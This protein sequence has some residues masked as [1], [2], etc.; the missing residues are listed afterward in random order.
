[1]RIIS[2]KR[3]KYENTKN[4]ISFKID[5]WIKEN[6]KRMQL[7]IELTLLYSFQFVLYIIN[8]FCLKDWISN[9]NNRKLKKNIWRVSISKFVVIFDK[10]TTFISIP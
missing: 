9:N 3:R 2:N 8:T 5:V 10:E 4:Y 7:I 1:M 6:V